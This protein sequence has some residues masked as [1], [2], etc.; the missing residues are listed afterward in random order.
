MSNEM[1]VVSSGI[2][3][4]THSG[5]SSSM[6]FA[7]SAMISLQPRTS[8]SCAFFRRYASIWMSRS[9]FC[10]SNSYTFSITNVGLVT[11]SPMPSVAAT[12]CTNVVFP[13]PS[14]P[15]SATMVAR[16]RGDSACTYFCANDF[17]CS[18]ESV[19]S[20]IPP[21][22]NTRTMTQF[23]EK[24]QEERLRELRAKEEEQLAAM[25]AGKYGVEYV[26]LTNKS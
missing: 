18:P 12:P 17:N 20:C 5:H 9:H 4:C 7:G 2:N 24:K 19:R 14:S 11:V 10:P 8:S 15:E 13:A 21:V 23:N 1:C 16:E 6:R 25:L 26:D 3:S 22:Y